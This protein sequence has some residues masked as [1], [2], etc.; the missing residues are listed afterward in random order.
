MLKYKSREVG[1]LY[2]FVDS[3]MKAISELNKQDNKEFYK[4]GIK[5][6]FQ[7]PT[8]GL[9]GKQLKYVQKINKKTL[10]YAKVVYS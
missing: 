3:W 1:L 2:T 8:E 7:L 4:P 10:K 6:V 5:D 9:S